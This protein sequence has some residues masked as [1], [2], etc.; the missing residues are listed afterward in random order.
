[1]N[2]NRIVNRYSSST[3][4]QINVR[5]TPRRCVVLFACHSAVRELVPHLVGVLH[6]NVSQILA[7]IDFS[8]GKIVSKTLSVLR[9]NF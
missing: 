4:L 1:M 2:W 3:I 6:K 5:S 9:K 8:S 7:T